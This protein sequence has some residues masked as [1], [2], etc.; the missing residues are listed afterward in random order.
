MKNLLLILIVS[1]GLLVDIKAQTWLWAQ[2]SSGSGSNEGTAINTDASGNV[3]ITGAFQ[4]STLTMGTYSLVNAGLLDIYISKYSSNGNLIWARSFGGNQT[5]IAYSICTD[6]NGDILVTGIF[7]SPSIV[8]DTY[9]LI[10]IGIE[11]IFLVKLDTDGNVLWAKSAGGTQLDEAFTIRTDLSSNIYIAGRF[12]SPIINFGASSLATSGTYDL[13]LAKYDT[14]GNAL[15]GQKAG[16]SG[17]DEGLALDIDDSENILLTGRYSSATI[18]FGNYTLNNA[19]MEDAYLVKYSPL[20]NALWAKNIGGTGVEAGTAISTDGIGNTY[21]TGRFSSTVLTANS[22]SLTNT[23]GIDAFL[24]KYDSNGNLIWAQNPN[25]NGDDIGWSISADSNNVF[26][27]GRFY[28]S[29]SSPSTISFNTYTFTPSSGAIDPMFIAKYDANGNVICASWLPS[30]GDDLFGIKV[31]SSGDLYMVNDFMTNPLVIGTTSLN[32]TGTENIFVAKFNCT[33]ETNIKE[34]NK[35]NL[36]KLFPNPNQ[37]NFIFQFDYEIE[38]GE[39]FLTNILG[40]KVHEQKIY[41]GEN[42]ITNCKLAKGI[43][44]YI[45]QENKRRIFSGKLTVE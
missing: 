17:L 5:D 24:I 44:N 9:T 29:F 28:F 23:G 21:I 1:F 38:S 30:G 19:G 11:N 4:A 42:N 18:T 41:K 13:Y 16:G 22:N 34:T 3:F 7:R 27:G 26:L 14:N 33:E 31:G 2:G 45:I 20:G 39:I 37:G 8:F 6:L 10:N 40:Q 35:F 32:L 36:V 43:Y 25:G 12:N 15:W